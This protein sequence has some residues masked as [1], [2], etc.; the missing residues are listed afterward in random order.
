[1]VFYVCTMYKI[2]NRVKRMRK[3]PRKTVNNKH[4][5]DKIWEEKGSTDIYIPFLISDY[6][7]W[8][9]GVDVADQRISYYRP[10]KL[11]CRRTWIPIFMQLLSIIR[12]NAYLVH[13]TNYK[14]PATQK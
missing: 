11:V 9:C 14:N 4:Y 3:R 2:G 5:I 8:M 1:M 13:R 6:N 12:N 10:S 7:Y